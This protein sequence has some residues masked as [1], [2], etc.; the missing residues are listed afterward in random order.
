MHTTV[1][2]CDVLDHEDSLKV[3]I[4]L[5]VNKRENLAMSDSEQLCTYPSPNPQQST[6]NKLGLGLV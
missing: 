4:M 1:T 6:N 5:C 3:R 2:N